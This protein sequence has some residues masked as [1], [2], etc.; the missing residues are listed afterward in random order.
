MNANPSPGN[1]AGG[2]TTILEKSLGAMA[3]AGY[4]EGKGFPKLMLWVEKFDGADRLANLL[5][6]NLAEKLGVNAET[7]VGSPAE[8][9]RAL[10]Q[11]KADLFVRHWGADYPDPSNFLE[12]FASKSGNNAT[13]WKSSDYDGFLE[14]ARDAVAPQDRISAFLRAE[15]LLVQ[16]EAVIVPL[17]YRRNIALLGP[18]VQELKISPLNYLFLK[19]AKVK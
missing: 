16:K 14:Q 5:L 19:D 7:R 6:R 11:G 18:R 15:Q 2:L 12:V 10:A 4:V 8:Y 1:K 9:Q 13:G 17:F 3:K